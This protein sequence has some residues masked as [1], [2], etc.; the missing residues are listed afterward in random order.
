MASCTYW[1]EYGRYCPKSGV[2][3]RCSAVEV[4]LITE[5]VEEISLQKQQAN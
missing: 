4:Y 1:R 3:Q 5:K 2:N